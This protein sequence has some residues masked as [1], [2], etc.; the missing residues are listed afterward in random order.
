MDI[1]I[2]VTQAPRELTIELDPK[3]ANDSAHVV[4]LFVENATTQMI[5]I[6]PR[7][8][9]QVIVDGKAG[10]EDL[11]PKH[12]GLFLSGRR[13]FE[14]PFVYLKPGESLKLGTASV[15]RLQPGRHT[16]RIAWQQTRAGWT[17]FGPIRH[18]GAPVYRKIDSVWT[19]V[20]VSDELTLLVR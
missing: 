7:G 11:L 13:N 14:D 8:E 6:H 5:A 3:R 15:G 1:R 12:P 4:A 19:G 16:L 18:D 20:V 2:G 10:I 9:S 17:D